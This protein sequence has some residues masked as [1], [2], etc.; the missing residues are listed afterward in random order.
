V[1]KIGYGSGD[2]SIKLGRI[3]LNFRFS[4][5]FIMAAREL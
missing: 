2:Y 1:L 3:K 5:S 4:C